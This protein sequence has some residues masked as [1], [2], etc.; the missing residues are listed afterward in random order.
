M[1]PNSNL[2]TLTAS[3]TSNDSSKDVP[4]HRNRLPRRRHLRA[5][6]FSLIVLILT[7]LGGGPA[8]AAPVDP[9][10]VPANLRQYVPD[11]AEWTA[12][13][14]MT[15]ESCRD[16]GGDWGT[17]AAYLIQDFPALLEFFQPRFANDDGNA[18][19]RK[20]LLIRGYQD[21]AANLTVPNGYCVDQVKSWAKTNPSYQPFGFEWGNVDN[22]GDHG[23]RPWSNCSTTN[24]E[25]LAPCRGFYIA[26]DGAITQQEDQRCQAWN[27]FSDDYVERMNTVLRKAYTQYGILVDGSDQTIN[28]IK[29]PGE[30]AQE[31]L[32][33]ITKKG[34]EQVVSFIVSG[35]TKLWTVFMRIATDFSSPQVTGVA[36]ASV[37]NLVAGV[38][39]ALA[40]LGWLITLSSS[41]RRGHLQFSLFGGIK[42]AVGVTLAGVG[43]ILMLQLAHDCTKSLISAGGDIA[44]QADFT[45][46]LAKAN[47]LV[48]IIAGALIGVSLIFAIIFMVVDAALVLM[49]T[50]FGSF[51]AAGQV[52]QATSGWLWKWAA[53]ATAMAWA[54]FFMVAVMLLSQ[55]LLLPLDPGEDPVQQVVDVV[56]G[57]A[58]CLLLVLCPW[59]LWELV[60][61]VGDRIGGPAASGGVAGRVASTGSQRGAAATGGAAGAAVRTMVANAREFGRG[62]AEGPQGRAA[63]GGQSGG[64]AAVPRPEPGNHGARGAEERTGDNGQRNADYA[65]QSL[66]SMRDGGGGSDG[67]PGVPPPANLG[68]VVA[69]AGPRPSPSLSEASASAEPNASSTSGERHEP[70]M[71][72]PAY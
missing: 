59:L 55:A 66:G 8:A 70:R 42:A 60:D 39:L 35:V 33:W 21:L 62:F 63:G 51:A 71:P 47:P 9:A 65:A 16:H 6:A 12:S 11:S 10:D 54:P 23:V 20:T 24:P 34:M 45:T 15:A 30:V 29:S 49:W 13:P 7:L 48:A 50:L 31:F 61:F 28:V 72:P 4:S 19:K 1:C 41:W 37:Y 3:T 67:I 22:M 5:L 57:L 69:N 53:R 17:Y 56:Q 27:S 52:H 36:F 14:W 46:S 40:F 18:P 32:N 64:G 26:C 68:R 38:A 43:A 2:T 25:D 44:Q 58:L